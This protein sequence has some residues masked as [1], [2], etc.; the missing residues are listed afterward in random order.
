MKS[1]K[2]RHFKLFSSIFEVKIWFNEK[3]RVQIAYTVTTQQF[4]S[5]LFK[6]RHSCRAWEIWVWVYYTMI[7]IS[8]WFFPDFEHWLRSKFQM[9]M[10]GSEPEAPNYTYLRVDHKNH[11]TIRRSLACMIGLTYKLNFRSL[12]VS[13][14]YDWNFCSIFCIEISN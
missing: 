5:C 8:L 14:L 13:Y 10:G 9:P 1:P 12:L 2:I 11:L 6:K 3:L 4:L 7:N